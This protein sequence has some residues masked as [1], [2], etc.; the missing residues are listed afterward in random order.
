M[1]SRRIS[2]LPSTDWRSAALTSAQ[3][4]RR[5]ADERPLVTES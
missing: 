5:G 1:H 2:G 3:D 4:E